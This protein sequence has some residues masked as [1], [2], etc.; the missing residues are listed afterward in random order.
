[1]QVGKHPK[2]TTTQETRE[3]PFV[4]GKKKGILGKKKNKL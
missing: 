4:K 3:K 2:R 1:M